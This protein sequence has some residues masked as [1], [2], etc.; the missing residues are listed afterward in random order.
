MTTTLLELEGTADE[1]SERLHGFAERKLHVTVRFAE[2]DVTA[3]NDTRSLE[4][5]LA[6]IADSIPLEEW[7]K[8]PSD[9]TEQLD[10][11]IYGSP[12]R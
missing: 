2:E 9:F 12:K 5:K 11:Y 7:Q 1:I 8:L 3:P 10:H 6:A 4:E